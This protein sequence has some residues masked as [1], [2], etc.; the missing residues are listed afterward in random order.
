MSALQRVRQLF[1]RVPDHP[2]V[3]LA[4]VVGGVVA[5]RA[6]GAGGLAYPDE[7]GLLLVADQLHDGPQLY[8][9]LFVDRPPGLVAVYAVGNL[10]GG[11]EAVRWIGIVL[12]VVL[13]GAASLLGRL[14]GSRQ[15]GIWTGIAA[16]ALACNPLLG[17]RSINAELVGAP[18]TVLGVLV[19]VAAVRRPPGWS[20]ALLLVLAG[21][22]G[23][24]A[25]MVKQNLADT[26]VFG[27]VLLA[28]LGLTRAWPARQVLTAYAWAALGLAV[29]WLVTAAWV[30]IDGPGLRVLW[31]TLYAFRV[32]ASAVI[33][34]QDASAPTRRLL[35]LPFLGLV[36]G[37]LMIVGVGSWR[38]RRRLAAR[39]PVVVAGLAMLA[40]E[41]AGVL[42]GGSYWSHYLV[43]LLPGAVLWMALLVNGPR[44]RVR[45]LVATVGVALG[46]TLVSSAVAVIPATPGD[47]SDEAAL[48]AWLDSAARPG[49]TGAV[50]WG[51]PQLLEASGLLPRS[52]LIW[53]LPQR[54]LDPDLHRF[55]KMLSG[56]RAPTWVLVWNPV[57]SWD[58]DVGGKA[59]LTLI[60]HYR[61]IRY[62]CDV[63]VY[64]RRD[65]VRVLP[66]MPTRCVD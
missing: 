54:T 1:G 47:R 12:V 20:R 43:G 66:P 37:L 49:D 40:A 19:T 42:L 15:A 29:P 55:K 7:G 18:L 26:V 30:V 41:V 46:S 57:D 51:H 27:T 32:T 31:D 53:S 50:T 16:A 11:I 24:A 23:S 35:T 63:G 33:A 22:L 59:T 65:V 4:L 25:L 44:G 2:W 64:V 52:P 10:L 60:A 34:D 48:V 39:D 56:R 38:L 17:T 21:L 14:V 9:R 5:L 61:F 62:V 3:V 58:L 28:V 6:P 13:V 45:V 8:G 36:S